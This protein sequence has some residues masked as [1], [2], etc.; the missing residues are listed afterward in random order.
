MVIE[1]LDFDLGLAIDDALDMIDL[2]E[3][4]AE[5]VGPLL[6][7]P[8]NQDYEDCIRVVHAEIVDKGGF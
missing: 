4:K 2:L 7:A 5:A 8:V 1:N 3:D 6:S